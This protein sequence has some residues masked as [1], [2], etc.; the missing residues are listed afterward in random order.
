MVDLPNSR[1]LPLVLQGEEEAVE[2]CPRAL[3]ASF[4]IQTKK[5]AD[6]TVRFVGEGFNF[7][8]QLMSRA[9][10]SSS[11]TTALNPSLAA[12]QGHQRAASAAAIEPPVKQPPK[13]PRAPD[14]FQERILKGDFYMD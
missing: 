10:R 2:V 7:G 13:S 6:V 14:H 4:S 5:V 11:I 9:Q 8:E 3:S 1:V 12:P